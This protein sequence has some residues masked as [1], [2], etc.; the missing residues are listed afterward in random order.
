MPYKNYYYYYMLV[1]N[2]VLGHQE[3]SFKWEHGMNSL[4][5]ST[6]Y[7]SL[8]LHMWGWCEFSGYGSSLQLNGKVLKVRGS[9]DYLWALL[10]STAFSK[11]WCFCT[12]VI[13][14]LHDCRFPLNSNISPRGR[15]VLVRSCVAIQAFY[16]ILRE[17]PSLPRPL[18]WS[19]RMSAR[20]VNSE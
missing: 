6:H 7:S 20:S 15:T 13:T 19:L 14:A 1:S 3:K 12:L 10:H 11:C 16:V 2:I 4:S 5:S 17:R 18:S 8:N 9:A